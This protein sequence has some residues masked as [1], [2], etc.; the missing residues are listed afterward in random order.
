[1][2]VWAGLAGGTGRD[3]KMDTTSLAGAAWPENGG[4]DFWDPGRPSPARISGFLGSN[5]DLLV[6]Q[7]SRE[8][9]RIARI[10]IRN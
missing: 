8:A 10:V 6:L 4:A 3:Q 7:G 9:E 1:M 2:A 5:A